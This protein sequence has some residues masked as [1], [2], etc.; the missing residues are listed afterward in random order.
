MSSIESQLLARKTELPSGQKEKLEAK[1][2]AG[3]VDVAA[4]YL[5]AGEAF[6]QIYGPEERASISSR[7]KTLDQVMTPQDYQASSEIWP[8]VEMIF[9]GWGMV[10]MD[11]A[12]FRRFPKLKVVFYGAGTVRNFVTDAFWKHKIRLTHAAAAN[13]VSVSEF[14]LSQILFA[15]KHGWQQASL[16]RKHRKFPPKYLPPGTYQTTVGL[17]SLGMIGRLVAE[18]L[19]PFD[20]NVVAYDP[21][22]P[23]KEAAKLKV[24]LLSLEE[25]FAVA[26]VVSCHTP[27]LRET[28]K[29][30]RRRHFESMKPGATFINTARGAVVE[31]EEMIHALKERPDLFALLDVTEP[32]PPVEGS[33][34]YTLDN[35]MLTPHIA[36]SLGSECRRMGKLMIEELDRFLA[37]KPLRHEIDE[38]RFQSMA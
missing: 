11:E 30:I 33:P 31:E 10:P 17:L 35:V 9:S 22:F 18:R 13:A 1:E 14:T 3:G 24:K 5:L 6:D 21:F 12:F 4:L 2:Q 23:P 16:I 38:K 25:V 19:Q 28:E 7:V 36:G 26:D 20:L 27:V 29:M 32:M 8:E 34:L 37:G 15:L